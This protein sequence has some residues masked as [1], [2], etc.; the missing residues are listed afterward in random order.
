MRNTASHLK[1]FTVG[2]GLTLVCWSFRPTPARASIFDLFS[3]ALQSRAMDKLPGDMTKD[4]PRSVLLNNF[5]LYVATGRTDRHVREVLDF[6]QARHQGGALKDLAGKPIAV[7]RDGVD[8]G[9][10]MTVDV[11]DKATAMQMMDGKRTL[12]SA[13]PLRMVYARRS[14]LYTDYMTIWSEKAMPRTILEPVQSGDAPGQ[15]VPGVP[16]PAGPRTLTFAEP[17]EGYM[18]VMYKVSEQPQEALRDLSLRIGASGW[19]EDRAFTKAAEK[20]KKLVVRF[21]KDQRDLVVTVRPAKDGRGTQ[22]AY[23]AR[24]LS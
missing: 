14:G 21:Q 18:L 19:N 10:L 17:N 9:T 8:T 24:D 7:R 16:R 15:D 23:L 1:L 13:G 4:K 11:P 6:Y 20:R 2:V 3:Q 22:V 5:P 12:T